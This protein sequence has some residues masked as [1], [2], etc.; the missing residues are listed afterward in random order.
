EGEATGAFVGRLT[1]TT[2]KLA[3]LY[4]VAEHPSSPLSISQEALTRAI[5]LV[6]WLQQQVEWL[7]RDGLAFTLADKQRLRVLAHIRGKPGVQQ[8]P[9]LKASHLSAR[10]FREVI[11]TLGQ[12]G[13]IE[14]MEHDSV[15]HYYARP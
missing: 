14:I 1:V 12:D 7:L 3:L 6:G 11:D 13:S 4:H 8:S 2:L 5:A 15:R 9:L 10:Q